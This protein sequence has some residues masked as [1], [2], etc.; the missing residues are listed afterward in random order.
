MQNKRKIYARK[1]NIIDE[2]CKKYYNTIYIYP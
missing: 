2:E 1:L